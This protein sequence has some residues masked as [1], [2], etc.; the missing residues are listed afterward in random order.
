MINICIGSPEFMAAITHTAILP[1]GIPEHLTEDH[2]ALTLDFDC[3]IRFGCEAPN[4]QFIYHHGVQ[5]N[6]IPTVTKFSKLVREA[7]NLAE[8]S[9]CIMTIKN[10]AI[11]LK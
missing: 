8:I 11:Q 5:S 7:S 6:A 2:R 9:T 1:F 3:R 10:L 4:Q